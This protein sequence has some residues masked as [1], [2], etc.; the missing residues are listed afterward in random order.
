MPGRKSG[1]GG[2][3]V[4]Y[5]PTAA[6]APERIESGIERA[7]ARSELTPG[8]LLRSNILVNR[9]ALSLD[10]A[11]TLWNRWVLGFGPGSQTRLMQ[12]LGLHRPGLRHLIILMTV[13]GS[14]FL[15]ALALLE[16]RRWQPPRDRVQKAYA[17]FCARLARITRPRRPAESPEQY[18]QA[19][20]KDRPDL[21]A[22]VDSITRL[23]LRL[24]YDGA[25]GHALVQH[26][27]KTVRVFKPRCAARS[28]RW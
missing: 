22:Q 19:V 7:L 18:A 12:L 27:C 26:F 1:S 5:D 4:R 8:R 15:L 2:A 28:S 21:A 14:L 6:V 10:A 17:L 3:W 9:L 16:Q 20:L 13:T 11:N 25:S 23:Y 24:R